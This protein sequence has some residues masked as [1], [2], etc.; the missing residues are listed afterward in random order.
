M[1]KAG[2]STFKTI[3]GNG[4]GMALGDFLFL[5]TLVEYFSFPFITVINNT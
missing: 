1:K 5:E 3:P 2:S 4:L